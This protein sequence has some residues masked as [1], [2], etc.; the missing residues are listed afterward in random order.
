MNKIE[1]NFKK[2]KALATKDLDLIKELNEIENSSSKISDRFYKNLD[3]GTAGIRG[4]IGAGTNRINVYVVGRI[5]QAFCAYLNGIKSNNLVAISFDNRIK[6]QLFAK[7]AAE[8]LAF[9]GIKVKIFKELK[10]VPLLSYAIRHYNCDG[11]IMITASHNPAEYNGYKIYGS[12]GGQIVEE[13]AKKISALINQIEMFSVKFGSFDEGLNSGLI[14]YC[15]DGVEQ[16]FLQS[17]AQ[18]LIQ[19]E[20]LKGSNLKLVYTPLNGSGME[21]MH[22]ILNQFKIENVYVVEQQKEPDGSFPTCKTPNPE[23]EEAFNLAL[24]CC[25]LHRPDV[26]IATDPDCDRIGAAAFDRE[27]CTYRILNGNQ[28]GVL[29][30]DYICKQRLA[31]KKMPSQ[32]LAMTTIVSTPMAEKIAQHYGVELETVLTGFKYIGERITE[33]ERQGTQSSFI[34]GFEESQGYLTGSYVRD[35][36]GVCAAM[37]IC[38]MV[39]FYKKQSKTLFDVLEELHKKFGYYESHVQSY[40]LEGKSGLDKMLE[41]MDYFRNNKIKKISNFNVLSKVDYLISKKEN[42]DSGLISLVNLP[43]SNVLEFGLEGGLKIVVRLSGT[44]PKLKIYYHGFGK[45]AAEAQN[46]LE[47]MQSGFVKHLEQI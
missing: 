2:W 44:E 15:D 21:P 11:G 1:E 45:T 43:K 4:L 19:P 22:R 9:N 47:L 42:L 8:V 16:N 29:M 10:P 38:E 26:A 3:F 33:L 34:F 17:V 31:L 41:I 20:L 32:P 18:N 36:D 25:K 6:S 12:D 24:K 7:V 23:Q 40:V 46:T 39:E 27:S 5:T 13:I 35:K 28:I 30:F 14:S 37:L